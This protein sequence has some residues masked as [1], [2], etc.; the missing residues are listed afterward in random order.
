VFSGDLPYPVIR[1]ST[2]A[3]RDT[4]TLL[5]RQL[6][7]HVLDA[8][9]S[10]HREFSL[11]KTPELAEWFDRTV[12][13]RA[14]QSVRAADVAIGEGFAGDVVFS[15]RDRFWW[16]DGNGDV[17]I[18]AKIVGGTYGTLSLDLDQYAPAEIAAM[19]SATEALKPSQPGVELALPSIEP[20]PEGAWVYWARIATS[21]NHCWIGAYSGEVFLLGR[22]GKAEGT[23]RLP[24]SLTALDEV[25]GA[26]PVA[27]AH[28]PGRFL[29][30]AEGKV[31][32]LLD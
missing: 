5:D 11:R 6:S 24:G 8:Y 27:F 23:W 25:S 30:D 19:A 14:Y 32:H 29:L 22:N 10:V 18:A 3:K 17:V 31:H 20:G 16:F 15:L 4:I 12:D 1:A 2:N 7:V 21:G 26:Q 13:D 9:G 28:A